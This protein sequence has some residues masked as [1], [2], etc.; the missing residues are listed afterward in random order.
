[1][2]TLSPTQL[3]N[4]RK[5]A[6]KKRA[7]AEAKVSQDPSMLYIAAPLKAPT[8]LDARRHF[9]QHFDFQVHVGPLEGWRTSCKLAVRASRGGPQIGLFAPG[10]HEV[11]SV[12]DC[13][14][15]H[16]SI[17]KAVSIVSRACASSGVKGYDEQQGSGDLRYLKMEVQRSSATVQLTLVWHASSRA[18]AG[19]CLQRLVDR[20]LRDA[21]KTW[22]AIWAN[23]NAADRHVS[24]I[25]E[26]DPEA[27]ERLAGKK[28]V[29]RERLQSV[30]LPYEAPLL[31]FPPFV[32]RQANLCAFENIISAVRSYVPKG[33][34]VVELYG[35]V[36]TIGLHLA[37]LVSSLV[38][39][40]ENPHNRQC[41]ER[42]A[43]ELPEELQERLSYRKGDAAAQVESIP[44]CD[45]VIVDPP[46]KG[47][48]DAILDA[49]LPSA[50]R[51]KRLG[52]KRLIYVSCG[53]PAL[54]RDVD[55]LMAGGWWV[56]HAGGY[57]LFPG[58]DH[59]ETLCV[60]D[61]E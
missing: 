42:S 56:S 51:K 20:L 35:G 28:R 25:L 54:K 5:R 43:K 47:L 16:P 44:G 18:T 3:R 45:L 46:R 58:A 29:L 15:H 37:D 39:S 55:R 4:A 31:C 11:C 17:N 48:D 24:R 59:I 2:E 7:K 13:P 1:M 33:S 49:F 52:P 60:L 40:D 19:P 10:S 26:Y 57:V 8:V 61:R 23:F 22:Y 53:F 6:A 36:G 41:F 21:P 12:T 27:W 34:K 30:R 50:P 9:S 32:F 38:C 14:A